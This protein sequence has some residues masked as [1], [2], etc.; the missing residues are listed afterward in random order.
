MKAQVNKFEAE[1]QMTNRVMFIF[2]LVVGSV[3]N[4]LN[5]PKDYGRIGISY[6]NIGK[7]IESE[8]YIEKFQ[9]R[10][11]VSMGAYLVQPYFEHYHLTGLYSINK[12]KDYALNQLKIFL[13]EDSIPY[14]LIRILKVDPF[15]DNIRNFPDFKKTLI[16]IETKFWKHHERIRVSLEKQLLLQIGKLLFYQCCIFNNYIIEIARSEI[17]I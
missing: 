7:S 16:E 9:S 6:E 15:F 10:T 5:D 3:T 2:L 11:R 1:H 13:N 12:E 17:F 14:W 4:N 8:E